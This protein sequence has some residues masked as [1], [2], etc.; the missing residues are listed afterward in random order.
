M[1]EKLFWLIDKSD[2]IVL[3]FF[4]VSIG[5]Y[6]ISWYLEVFRKKYKFISFLAKIGAI[7]TLVVVLVSIL[8]VNI[9][10]CVVLN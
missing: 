9:I 1:I 4:V 6:I 10:L 3:A 8:T 7:S 2:F 5:F